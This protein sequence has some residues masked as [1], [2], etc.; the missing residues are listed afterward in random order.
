MKI[1]SAVLVVTVLLSLL[2]FFGPLLLLWGSVI[3]CL[4]GRACSGSVDK[5]FYFVITCGLAW[6]IFFR[7]A[8]A[9]VANT[10]ISLRWPAA[11]LCFGIL[12]LSWLMGI[13][14][15]PVSALMVA[16]AILLAIWV[17][18]YHVAGFLRLRRA[19]AGL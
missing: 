16:P 4:Q 9:W 12:S 1:R 13:E 17:S 15:I 6:Y 7:M 10:I 5:A 11:G 18:C 14:M 2:G 3:T 8:R 19:A